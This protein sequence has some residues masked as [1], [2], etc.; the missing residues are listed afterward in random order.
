VTDEQG[1]YSVEIKGI[2]EVIYRE[3][4]RMV[5]F[6]AHMRDHEVHLVSTA[7]ESGPTWG[8]VKRTHLMFVI[9]SSS[10]CCWPRGRGR[11]RGL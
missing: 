6:A 9:L 11:G 7:L 10:R 2:G 8:A 1:R 4:E 5:V 3:P